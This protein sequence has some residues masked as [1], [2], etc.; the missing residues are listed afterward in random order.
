MLQLQT[1][2]TQCLTKAASM[3]NEYKTLLAVA[4]RKQSEYYNQ[5]MPAL[6]AVRIL[7]AML[8]FSTLSLAVLLAVSPLLFCSLIF[9]VTFS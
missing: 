9:L 2:A 4:N 7:Q 6:L 1:K 5:S 3:D 8:L